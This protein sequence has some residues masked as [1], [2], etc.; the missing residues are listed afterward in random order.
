MGGG[1]IPPL[2]PLKSMKKTLLLLA[3]VALLLVGC[4]KEKFAE[5]IDGGLTNVTFTASLDNSVA[6][7]AAV[8]GDGAAASVNRCIMEIYYGDELY[9]RQYAKV[10]DK[11]ATFTAQMVSNRKYTV[12]FWADCVADTTTKAGLATDKYYTTTSLKTI[13]L[14][15]SY[16]G[17]DDAR[18]AFFHVKEYTVAQAGSSFGGGENDKILLKRPFAQMN[19]I[20]TDWDKAA[21]VTGLAPEKVKVTLKNALVNFNAVT[22]EAS[23]SQTLTYTADVYAPAASGTNSEIKTLSMDYL[24][25]PKTDKAFIDI[26]W[27]ALHGTDANVEHSFAAVPYQRNYR[28]NIKGALLTTT[29]QWTVTVDSDWT[30]DGTTVEGSTDPYLVNYFAAG[31]IAAANEALKTNN[32]VSIDNPT[33]LGTAI[34]IPTEQDGESVY[35]KVTG[36]ASGGIKVKKNDTDNGPASLAIESDSETLNIDLPNSHVDVNKGANYTQI[37]AKT[38]DN[39]LVIGKDVVATALEVQKGSVEIHGKVDNLT[40]AAGISAKFY[41]SDGT[42]L[43]NYVTW[44][45]AGETVELECDIDLDG[46]TW[47]SLELNADFNGNGH[48]IKNIQNLNCAPDYAGLFKVSYSNIKNVTIQ[49]AEFKYGTETLNARGGAL[50]GDMRRGSIENCHVDGVKFDGYQKVGGLVGFISENADNGT[51]IIIKNCS[52]MNATFAACGAHDGTDDEYLYQAGGL[53]GYIAL[54]KR[55]ISISNCSVENIIYDNSKFSG[56][57]DKLNTNNG[58]LSHTFV[59]A[60]F[61]Q[62]N[63]AANTL[64]FTANTISGT[65]TQL[66]ANMYGSAYFGW[67]RNPEYKSNTPVTLGKI[68]IDGQEWT[69]NYPFKN[70]TTGKGYA[71]LDAALTALKAS[72]TLE[73]WKA[74]EYTVQTLS[75]PANTTIDAKVDDVV[76]KHTAGYTAWVASCENTTVKNVTWKV[77]TAEYQYFKGIHAENCTFDGM[78]TTHTS[79]SFTNCNFM[80]SDGYKYCAQGYGGDFTWTDCTFNCEGKAFYAYNEGSEMCHFTFNNCTF[81]EVVGDR[82]ACKAAILVKENHDNQKY[83]V[84]INGCEA[85]FDKYVP[86]DPDYTGSSLWNMELKDGVT[87]TDVTVNLNGEKVY[88]F[89]SFKVNDVAGLQRAVEMF[90]NSKQKVEHTII[91]NDGTYEVSGLLIRKNLT[92]KSLVMKAANPKG[93]TLKVKAGGQNPYIFI[94]DGCSSYDETRATSFEGINFDLSAISSTTAV[95]QSMSGNE[96]RYGAGIIFDG[97]DLTGGNSMNL[98]AMYFSSPNHSS[99][100]VVIKNC[101]IANVGYLA[102]CYAGEF[103]AENVTTTTNVKHFINNQTSGITT[104]KNC[105]VN[106]NTDYA[107]RT[108]G[109]SISITG[110]TFN[111]TYSESDFGGIY[112]NRRPNAQLTMTGNTYPESYAGQNMHDI[113]NASDIQNGVELGGDCIINGTTTIHI[114]ETYD[115]PRQ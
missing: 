61:S 67:A 109:G 43:A 77:G 35:V 91:V 90:N 32:A 52:V 45:K 41:A 83:V 53:V 20:T 79:G 66:N 40:R 27:K 6:T 64:A 86:D 49:D 38:G 10:T 26:D 25:A 3:S 23:G 68:T 103:V 78:I 48:I 111:M 75:T 84:N 73:I 39:T 85:N 93:A 96:N 99:P 97:C 55:N 34:T 88:P 8:D 115:F 70:V 104:V 59:G 63:N 105:V 101:S 92:G 87:G 37:T 47:E 21:S 95:A 24:F 33:D 80:N 18:D 9:A 50:V 28:T 71:T 72:E 76:F 102:S 108:N 110:S 98:N 51:N 2:K 11:K 100:N 69:P 22:G 113:Y 14:K 54:G 29:G 4:A 1:K 114:K 89:T 94:F 82:T 44:A 13:A 58:Y 60:I 5:P 31:S 46:T 19:V 15:G 107:I 42:T 16:I 7:K 62:T 74:G 112:V 17:N 106:C 36:A 30:G 65:N 81:N 56:V 57:Y 12:A